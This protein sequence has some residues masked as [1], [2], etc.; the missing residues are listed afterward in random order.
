MAGHLK[1]DHS[2]LAQYFEPVAVGPRC[3]TPGC[4]WPAL[5][6]G[7][8]KHC[9]YDKERTD[10]PGGSTA[11]SCIDEISTGKRTGHGPPVERG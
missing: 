11:A 2:H 1:S 9:N 6:N 8:C 5:E 4:A 3:Q 10:S 7:W